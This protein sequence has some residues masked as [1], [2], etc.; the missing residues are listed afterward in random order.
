MDG[1]Q[2]RPPINEDVALDDKAVCAIL[3]ISKSTLMRWRVEH[4]CPQPS[5]YVGQRGFT[6][7]SDLNRW[8]ASRP[9]ENGFKGQF[10]PKRKPKA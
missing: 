10:P 5:F 7:R 2:A 3:N 4:D 8:V 6:W 9:D 1:A